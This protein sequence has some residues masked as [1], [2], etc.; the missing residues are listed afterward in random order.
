MLPPRWW[1]PHGLRSWRMRFAADGWFGGPSSWSW[2]SW[3]GKLF[4]GPISY[5]L[6][7]KKDISA[8]FISSYFH[9]PFL[10]T[11]TPICY[12]KALSFLHQ[13]NTSSLTY[14]ALWPIMGHRLPYNIFGLNPLVPWKIDW[15]IRLIVYSVFM[16]I[17]KLLES[18]ITYRV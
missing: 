18:L 11:H 5:Q 6:C 14:C 2:V 7:W 17:C 13:H 4:I 16:C 12:L 10:Q 3:V 15:H 9:A 8:N 1:S